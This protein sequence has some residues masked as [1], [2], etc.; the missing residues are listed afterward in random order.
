MFSIL[1]ILWC[2]SISSYLMVC[3][4]GALSAS[5]FYRTNR[6]KTLNQSHPIYTVR[7][8]GPVAKTPAFQ[9]GDPGS[10]PGLRIA[11]SAASSRI[12]RKLVFFDFTPRRRKLFLGLSDP[13]RFPIFGRRISFFRNCCLK[14]TQCFAPQKLLKP[15]TVNFPI[16]FTLAC[17]FWCNSSFWEWVLMS[18][19]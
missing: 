4:P 8:V 7:G 12:L 11:F 13:R 15:G 19:L 5:A 1:C 10:N 16:L 14:N 9:A 18:C 17:V 2:E 6:F 3:L